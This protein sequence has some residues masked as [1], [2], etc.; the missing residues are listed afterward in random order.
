MMMQLA[1]WWRARTDRERSLIRVAAILIFA[2][3]APLWAFASASAFRQSAAAEFANAQRI[4]AQIQQLQEIARAQGGEEAAG[5]SLR[6][7]VLATAQ[8]K[9]LNVARLETAGQDRV[10]VTFEAAD[11]NAV[12]AWIQAVG[13]AGA[14]VERAAIDR[15]GDS[16]QVIAEFEV[17]DQS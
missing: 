9:G 6:E 10:R 11:S 14:A 2:I 16:D 13:G 17:A 3:M 4:G 1:A 5:G 7:R 12:Y 15:V 8:G